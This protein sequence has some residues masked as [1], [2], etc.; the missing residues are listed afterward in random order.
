MRLLTPYPP[1]PSTMTSRSLARH[2]LKTRITLTMLGL[3]VASIWAMS[4][5][6]SR[7]LREDVKDLLGQQQ[8]IAVSNYAREADQELRERLLWLETV[9]AKI[10]PKTL[11]SPKAMQEFLAQRLILPRLFNGGGII[12]GLDGTALADSQPDSGRIGVNYMDVDT[13]VTALKEGKPN[14]GKAVLGKKLMAPVFGMTV[15]IRDASGRV[16]GAFAGVTNLGKSNFLDRIQQGRFGNTG[17]YLLV[18]RNERLIITATDKTRMMEV[19]PAPGVNAKLDHFLGGGEGTDVLVSPLG[20]E[21][22]V[23]VKT[24]PVANWYLAAILPTTEA[25][26]PVK[27]LHDRMLLATAILTL[28]VGGIMWW[29]LRRQLAPMV[30]AA[31]ALSLQAESD[32]PPQGL[33]ILRQDEIGVLVAAFNRL[34]ERI[35]ER[36]LTLQQRDKVLRNILDTSLDGFWRV[37]DQGRLM[38]VNPTYCQQSG[39]SREELIGRHV[40]ELDAE[41][42]PEQT[43]A[44]IRRLMD[45]G[46]DQ[47]ES[48][49][50]RKDG[51]LWDIEVSATYSN[52]SDGLLCAFIRDITQRKQDEREIRQLNEELEQRVRDRTAALETSNQL[53]SEA[54]IRAETA[55]IAKSAFLANMSHEIRTPLNAITGMAYILRNSGLTAQQTDKLDKIEAAGNHLLEIINAILDLSKIEAG[56]Y[57][58]EEGIVRIDQIIDTVASMVGN[59]VKAKGL[60]LLIDSQSMPAGLL[61]DHTRLQQA[62]LNYLANAVKFTE[63]G[64]IKISTQVEEETPDDALIRFAVTDTGIGI[65]AETLPRL[66]SAFEQADNTTTRKYGGTGLGL[67]ITRKIAQM[68]GGDAGATSQPGKGSTFWFTVRLR[69]SLLDCNPVV[70]DDL[71]DAE[72][73]LK[74]AHAGRRILLAEDEPINREIA[75]LMLDEVGLVVDTAEDGAEALRLASKNDYALILMDM[76]MPHMDGLEAARQIR[77]LPIGK[78]IPILAMTANAFAEDKAHCIDAGMNDFITKPVTPELLYKAL[79]KWLTRKGVAS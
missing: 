48:R 37:D 73:A 61:G 2:S 45:T 66:F 44:R 23:S 64:S 42:H 58:I 53:L 75:T 25:F 71:G 49:H 20:I 43:A 8:R 11:A 76:Q 3:F 59:T 5:Y 70:L 40:S 18:S 38:D 15:P 52:A 4:Y 10:T 19:L 78:E 68:M 16:I 41:E 39:Y 14:I 65:P 27:V 1:P 22:L 55:N 32:Q 63:T 69:K 47:F 33:P 7:M 54:K 13:I 35:A 57:Q 67:A 28:L 31:N 21:V 12:Y 34:L 77:Q 24:I 50:R 17:G 26:A 46:R 60:L 62:L 9:A 29:M 30:E 72:H 6:A 56:R 79:L 74:T 51:S 36:D